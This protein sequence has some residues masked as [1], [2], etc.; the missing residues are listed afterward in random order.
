MATLIK[1]IPQLRQR[2]RFVRALGVNSALLWLL[3]ATTACGTADPNLFGSRLV[4][5]GGSPN[6]G[7]WSAAGSTGYAGGSVG[8]NAGD[9][10]FGNGGNAGSRDSAAGCA[11]SCGGGGRSHGGAPDSV[12]GTEQTDRGSELSDCSMFA[13]GATFLAE[14]KHCYL[15]DKEQRTFSA[16]EMHCKDL[17]A[18]LVTLDSEAE[19]AF[20]W[21][22][23]GD[24]H[25][26][27]SQDG[28]APKDSGVGRYGWITSEP[29]EF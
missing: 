13:E 7:S 18:H 20:A 2:V 12:G 26:I 4:Q 28:K 3:F 24:E 22:L 5:G 29:F 6:A 16:A 27:G 8:G 9:T 14:T 11:F 25:W 21:S 10:V 15:V 17:N 19:D 23:H 1:P